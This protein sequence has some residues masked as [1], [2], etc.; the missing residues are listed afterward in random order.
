MTQHDV[1]PNVIVVYGRCWLPV[2]SPNLFVTAL[3]PFWFCMLTGGLPFEPHW[4][5][6]KALETV[7]LWMLILSGWA[8]RQCRATHPVAVCWWVRKGGHKK[9][10]PT[11]HRVI[12]L[13]L[14][15][16]LSCLRIY[17]PHCVRWSVDWTK[18]FTCS[19]RL[20]CP[21]KRQQQGA[22]VFWVP[23]LS[24]LSSSWSLFRLR[25]M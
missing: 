5:H 3:D 2:S 4:R 23:L 16:E 8:T 20:W 22:A 17:L 14:G 15:V 9:V 1:L 11:L 25:P 24:S 10:Q 6:Q 12:P 19:D 7:V 13:S 21:G 18:D